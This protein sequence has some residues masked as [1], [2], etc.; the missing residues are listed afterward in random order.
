MP[1]NTPTPTRTPTH[2]QTYKFYR[3]YKSCTLH[4]NTTSLQTLQ[5]YTYNPIYL[6]YLHFKYNVARC[7]RILS[8]IDHCALRCFL[9]HLLDLDFIWEPPEDG[10]GVEFPKQI[11]ML[12][13]CTTIIAHKECL[14]MNTH[15]HSHTRTLT[16]THTHS[17]THAHTHTHTRR[18]ERR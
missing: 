8:L 10:R 6:P 16:H 3:S 15:T 14:A 2:I 1:A 12:A 9:D 18:K 17:C 7:G 5:Q 11:A 13:D 4:Y